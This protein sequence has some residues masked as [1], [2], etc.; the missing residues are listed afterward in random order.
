[1]ATAACLPIAADR[2]GPCVRTIFFEGLDL[3]GIPLSLEARLKPE[4]PGAAAIALGIGATA[5]A[6]GMRLVG[7]TFT[8]G[9]PTSQ[10]TLR[11]NETTMKDA[12]KVPYVGELGDVS[13]L[14]YDLI[15]L[16]GQD[17]RRLCYGTLTALP[18]TY[19]MD[20][21]PAGRS[22][23]RSFADGS[24]Q[25]WNSAT[26][27][28]GA[29]TVVVRIDGADLLSGLLGGAKDNA[30]RAQQALS[31][32]QAVAATLAPLSSQVQDVSYVNTVLFDEGQA[33]DTNDGA[34]TDNATLFMEGTIGDGATLIDTITIYAA[35]SVTA[36]KVRRWQTNADNSLSYLA[37]VMTVALVDGANVFTA[38]SGAFAAFVPAAG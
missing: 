32:T 26:L 35:T 31:D 13:T 1:M 19:G 34:A 7:V 25:T 33:A 27:S 23:G 20:A 9:I 30:Y 38:K 11:I 3:N 37:T 28:F 18:T 21:A 22:D 24:A 2:A 17:K 14:Y 12:S 10:V 4:T 36:C 6:E 5:N 15:G 16:F 8:D 29:E